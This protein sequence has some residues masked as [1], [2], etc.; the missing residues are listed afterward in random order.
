[1]SSMSASAIAVNDLMY[2][3][4]VSAATAGS[5]QI[6]MDELDTRWEETL[7]SFGVTA[8][9]AELNYSIGLTNN[10][11][12]Q[13]NNKQVAG[14]Y[15][16]SINSMTGP[17]INIAAGSSGSDFNVATASNVVTVN[18]PDAS[19]TNR[20]C[21]TSANF[22]TFND[23]IGSI[24]GVTG[25]SISLN[26]TAGNISISSAA[27]ILIADLI[28]TTVNPGSYNLTN[29]TVDSKGRITSATHGTAVTQ[30]TGTTDQITASATSGSVTLS[31]PSN[32][33]ITGN[34][35][36]ASINLSGLIASR[37]VKTDS[38]KNL[39]SASI[40]LSSALDVFS[41]L[42]VSNGGTGLSSLTSGA[43]LLGSGT[44]PV[45]SV[46]R[47]NLQAS[48]S[49]IQVFNGSS[50]VL[51]TTSVALDLTTTG[52]TAA[53]YT[54]TNLTVDAYGRITSASNGSGGSGAVTSVQGTTNQISTN[55]SVG[56]IVVSM[57]TDVAI[58]GN[59]TTQSINITSLNGAPSTSLA[60]ISGGAIYSYIQP[61]A[62]GQVLTTTAN[63]VSFQNPATGNGSFFGSLVM[64]GNTNC[65]WTTTQA[66]YNANFAADPDCLWGTSVSGSG[67]VTGGAI[68]IPQVRI[69]SATV[70]TYRVRAQC[71]FAIAGSAGVGFG[72]ALVDGDNNRLARQQM[73]N[74]NYTE[75]GVSPVGIE[76]Y[77]TVSSTTDIAINLRMFIE[78]GATLS[79]RN[80]NTT[81]ECR[82]DVYKY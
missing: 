28:N 15:I 7:A 66:D 2:I 6:R 65:I 12:S 18:C 13:L 21:L 33:S 44:G 78:S 4:D 17:G 56:A 8:S 37:P 64:A 24:S 58:T 51:G 43:V 70:G 60:L 47:Q 36:S 38:L 14:N 73:Y 81:Q 52:V 80:N 25:S 35:S 27:A 63:S 30:I 34:L 11:Q 59:L 53:S 40:D 22:T 5:M 26:G 71:N 1:M 32:V 10:I 74:G 50:S 31:L 16:T 45:N 3:V 62:S 54:N 23:K 29:L 72:Q 55:T 69:L 82:F 76:A 19:G 42:G 61:G 46:S 77:K 75:A 79:L 20:G 68:L 67:T 39:T 9:A 41:I 57:T 48:G 49:S